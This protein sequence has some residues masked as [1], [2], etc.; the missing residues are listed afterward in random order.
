MY[1][2]GGNV[3]GSISAFV[4]IIVAV[5]F[6]DTAGGFGVGVAVWISVGIVVGVSSC[7]GF[8]F[9]AHP[10]RMNPTAVSIRNTYSL[11]FRLNKKRMSLISSPCRI[12]RKYYLR[13]S[14]C[15]FIPL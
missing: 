2:P 8:I 11:E 9:D 4:G 13:E 6:T 5:G 1:W 7:E 3:D 14:L 12:R 10:F 15:Y